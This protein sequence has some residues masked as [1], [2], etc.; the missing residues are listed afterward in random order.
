MS[1]EERHG[2]GGGD[3]VPVPRAGARSAADGQGAPDRAMPPWI[4]R[5]IGLVLLS[6]AGFMFAWWAFGR[7]KG[8]LIILLVSMF[9][10]LAIEPAVNWLADRGMRRGVATMVL[11]LLLFVT[12]VAFSVALGSLLVSELASI[13]QNLPDYAD[14]VIKLTNDTFGTRLSA[15]DLPDKLSIN[16]QLLQNYGQSAAS[17]VVNLS[18]SVLGGLFKL[19][20]VLLFGFYLSAE[21]PKFRRYVVSLFP[22][23]KQSEVLRAWEITIDKTGGYIYSRALM[24]VISF[25]AHYVFFTLIG[26]PYGLALAAWVGLVS[27]F[28]PTVGT[29][30]AGALPI[31]VALAEQPIDALWILIFVL[32]YQQFENYLVQ[33][34]I[35]AKTLQ[36]HPAVAFGAV[37]AGAALLGP[38][39]GFLGIPLAASGQAFFSTYIRRY[40]IAEPRLAELER[41]QRAAHHPAQAA[42]SATAGTGQ[43]PTTR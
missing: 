7:L 10:S 15:E 39:G 24:A 18:A 42:Q 32:V 35:T 34:R 12:M 13:V 22:P 37:I 17:N 43:D 21:G 23:S 33:P 6:V 3:P 28:I 27:Q 19:F 36:V 31:L 1:T 30:L 25:V 14:R 2:T 11:F 9:L 29:Y 41:I 4:P 40:E 8:L 38:V 16:S 26:L 20:T 5:A